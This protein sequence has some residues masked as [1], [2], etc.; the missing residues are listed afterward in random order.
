MY[1]NIK[2]KEE[3]SLAKEES[4]ILLTKPQRT[5][6]GSNK[7]SLGCN[8]SYLYTNTQFPQASFAIFTPYTRRAYGNMFL[9]LYFPTAHLNNDTHLE[10]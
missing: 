9:L 10:K 3:E 6:S 2:L 4:M 5:C 8:S 7:A 1:T